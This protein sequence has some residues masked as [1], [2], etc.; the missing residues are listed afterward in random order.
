MSAGLSLWFD[1]WAA[2]ARAAGAEPDAGRRLKGWALAAG[3]Q[4]E[5]MCLT[6]GTF[7]YSTPVERLWWGDLWADRMAPD[8]QFAKT[9]VEGGHATLEQLALMAQAWRQ[10][11]EAPDATF[12]M[13]HGEL[14]VRQ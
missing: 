11:A 3:F 5:D 10:W 14:L 7:C 13:A 8:G 9:A 6:A 2:V 12:I 1:T 4:E